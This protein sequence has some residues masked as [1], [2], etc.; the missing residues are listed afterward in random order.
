MR[1]VQELLHFEKNLKSQPNFRMF[2][3]DFLSCAGGEREEETGREALKKIVAP[4][5]ASQLNWMGTSKKYAV[6]GT[7]L[8]SVVYDAC[9][10]R[11]Q[12]EGKR[13]INEKAIGILWNTGSVVL[14]FRFCLRL[15]SNLHWRHLIDFG[16]GP[17]ATNPVHR[18][19]RSGSFAS[20][21]PMPMQTFQEATLSRSD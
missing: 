14:G 15:L 11:F 21:S 5:L 12:R 17:S 4:S 9:K 13:D 20:T 7:E 6:Q 16:K 2:A 19:D 3:V 1:T 8:M 18:G 10:A